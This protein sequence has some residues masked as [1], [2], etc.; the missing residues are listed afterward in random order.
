MKYLG[1][2]VSRKHLCPT[3]PGGRAEEAAPARGCPWSRAG[4]R[5]HGSGV[6]V[7]VEVEVEAEAEV[8]GTRATPT[9]GQDH[10]GRQERETERA[11]AGPVGEQWASEPRVEG[12][13][14]GGADNEQ[15]RCRATRRGEPRGASWSGTTS[16]RPQQRECQGS[17]PGEAR[18][19]LLCGPLGPRPSALGPRP[20]P[21]CGRSPNAP[22][23]LSGGAVLGSSVCRARSAC[24]EPAGA[25][26][27]HAG[28]R[29]E[30]A[31]A[32]RRWWR[33]ERPAL[34]ETQRGE[35]AALCSVSA[36]GGRETWE[37]S[38]W[39]F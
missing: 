7:E 27:P 3:P 22:G 4:V 8:G 16:R 9:G 5:G 20:S 21:C 24:A 10:G 18:A 2:A 15:S 34:P 37:R 36:T 28:G 14:R 29:P 1:A 30:S 13:S 31:P 12:P 26:S 19:P 33:E 32:R 23:R 39:G 17:S 25:A 38:R 35:E 6:T 11:R